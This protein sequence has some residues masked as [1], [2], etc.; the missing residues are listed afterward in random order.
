MGIDD[1]AQKYLITKGVIGVRRIDK[2]ELRR[3]AKSSGAT[4]VTTLANTDGT[5]SFGKELI[6]HAKC[7][8]EDTVGD[9]DYLFIDV[10]LYFY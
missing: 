6:G 7:V 2:S 8:Y 10:S 3:I 1:L 5:E 4:L 9:M